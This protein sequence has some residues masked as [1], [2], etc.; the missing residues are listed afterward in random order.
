MAHSAE[1]LS[2][3]SNGHYLKQ[4]LES[5]IE[6]NASRNVHHLRNSEVISISNHAR[7]E[8]ES[9]FLG[10]HDQYLDESELRMRLWVETSMLKIY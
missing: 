5:P 6:N 3:L 7:P 8:S 2:Y 10:D 9:N 4:I 1:S